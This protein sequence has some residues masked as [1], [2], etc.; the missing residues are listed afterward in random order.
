MTTRLI[1]MLA[2]TGVLAACSAVPTVRNSDLDHARGIFNAALREEQV[3]SL[4]PQEL[5]QASDSLAHAQAAWND[6][7]PPATVSHLAYLAAQRT[8]IAQDLAL[9]RAAKA[10]VAGAAAERD[11]MRLAQRTAEADSA[12]NRL[13][14]AEHS[15][16][17][18]SAALV[19]ADAMVQR[20]QART[21]A[22][23]IELQELNAKKTDRGWVVTLGDVLFEVGRPG[24]LPSVPLPWRAC[25]APCSAMRL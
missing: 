7:A 23:A 14:I 4:A 2:L 1:P 19:Q 15:S 16:A 10:V 24:W 11:Q 18:K 3:M 6:G 13:A 20:S 12:R 22:L 25:Q 5:T 8:A 21:N 17:E 9:Q